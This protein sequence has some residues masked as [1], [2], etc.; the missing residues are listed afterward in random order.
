MSLMSEGTFMLIIKHVII[1]LRIC[2]RS[3]NLFK[4]DGTSSE[5]CDTV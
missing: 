5:I 3:Y 4:N 2:I 1:D